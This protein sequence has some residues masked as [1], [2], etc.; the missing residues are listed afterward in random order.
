[1]TEHAQPNP[2]GW[3]LL[4]A[5][6]LAP[7]IPAA[8]LAAY[9][10]QGADGSY[11]SNTLILVLLFGAYPSEIV[12]GVPA[13]F[14][15]RRLVAPSA[16]ACALAGGMVATIPWLISGLIYGLNQGSPGGAL[17]FPAATFALGVVG[18]LVFWAIA[19]ATL[20]PSRA[21]ATG[22]GD[23]SDN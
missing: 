13:Y 12:L 20:R 14:I 23:G 5:F 10:W 15:L 18:G 16:T 2:S 1:M 3:R 17:M 4:S 9:L 6:V 8:F 21:F 19:V 11:F 7:V 22:G